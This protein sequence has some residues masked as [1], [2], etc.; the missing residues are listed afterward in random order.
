[1]LQVIYHSQ[2]ILVISDHSG[3]KKKRQTKVKELCFLTCM[4]S[5]KRYF[6]NVGELSRGAEALLCAWQGLPHVTTYFGEKFCLT[7][8]DDASRGRT[9][10]MAYTTSAFVTK[11]MHCFHKPSAGLCEPPNKAK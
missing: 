11:D 3:K 4:L 8:Y 10:A 2:N 6:C 9:H 7:L 1:M 5:H